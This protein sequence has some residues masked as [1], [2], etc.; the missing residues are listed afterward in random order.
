MREQASD[1][2]T[3]GKT[4]SAVSKLNDKTT[5]LPLFELRERCHAGDGGDKGNAIEMVLPSLYLSFT[6]ILI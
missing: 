1:S 4:R 2:K 3:E 6:L 5:V